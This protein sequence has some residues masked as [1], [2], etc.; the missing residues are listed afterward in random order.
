MGTNTTTGFRLSAEQERVCVQQGDTPF[1]AQCLVSLGRHSAPRKSWKQALGKHHSAARNPAHGLPSPGRP[2]TTLPG[3]PRHL[4][5]RLE[6]DRQN[7]PRRSR[8]DRFPSRPHDP[9][10]HFESG[11]WPAGPR[12]PRRA[13]T[14]KARL[15]TKPSRARRRLPEPLTR[16]ILV[17]KKSAATTR[18]SSQNRPSKTK[19]CNTSTSRA[20]ADRLTRKRRDKSLPRLLARL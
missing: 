1:I 7:H 14:A 11:R 5:A 12:L 3:H 9:Y 16:T 17:R 10:P 18:L 15:H 19:P 13:L 20:M 2:Q 6:F 4:R 8:A